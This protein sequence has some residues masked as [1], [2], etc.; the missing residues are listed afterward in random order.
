MVR[1]PELALEGRARLY[2]LVIESTL[3]CANNAPRL[4]VIY[5]MDMLSTF[6]WAS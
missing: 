1:V 6:P 2:L 3:V 5:D 4:I